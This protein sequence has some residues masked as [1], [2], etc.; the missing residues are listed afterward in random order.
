MTDE[1]GRCGWLM[2]AIVAVIYASPAGLA[3]ASYPVVAWMLVL[4][5]AY[6]S[7]LFL[8]IAVFALWLRV[9]GRS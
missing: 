1:R 7:G 2:L 8:L 3:A 4:P 9:T 6:W 5:V